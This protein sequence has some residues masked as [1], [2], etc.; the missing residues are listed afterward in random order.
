[1]VFYPSEK[2]GLFIDGANLYSASKALDFDLDYKKLLE[3]FQKRSHLVRAYYYTALIEND[4][5][6]PLRPLMDWLDYNG[7]NVVTKTAREFTDH[8]GHRRIKGSMDVEM[9]IDILENS[10]YLDHIVL[11]SGDGN[12]STS[13]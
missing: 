1:M 2:L 3:E 5:Y 10:S 7:F 4:D 11:F 9:S 13:Y 6:S 8:Y 12:F